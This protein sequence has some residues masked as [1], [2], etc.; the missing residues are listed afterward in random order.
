MA[1]EAK[2]DPRQS[3][4]YAA[5]SMLSIIGMGPIAVSPVGKAIYHA[6]NN[7]PLEPRQGWAVL[8]DLQT[9][10]FLAA[11]ATVAVFTAGHG[12]HVSVKYLANQGPGGTR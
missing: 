8:L 11:M 7:L 3:F 1:E 9:S 6:A 5:M 10:W 4:Q 12:I 2:S